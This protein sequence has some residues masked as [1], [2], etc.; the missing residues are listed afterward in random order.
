MAY[1]KQTRIARVN[2]TT[3]GTTTIVAGGQLGTGIGSIHVWQ[4]ELNGAGAN[5]ITGTTNATLLP[6]EIDFT[7][8][9]AAAVLQNTEE[10]WFTTLPGQSFGF[11]TTTTAAVTGAIYYTLA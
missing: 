2:I 9:G 7:A 1:Q 4:V 5:V 8:A 6:G 10:P 11:N 3:A